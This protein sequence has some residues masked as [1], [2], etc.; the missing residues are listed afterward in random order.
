MGSL[1]QSMLSALGDR[2]SPEGVRRRD[3]VFGTDHSGLVLNLVSKLASVLE[4]LENLPVYLYDAPGSYNL[5]SFSK[6]FRIGLKKDQP[7]DAN[8]LDYT[9]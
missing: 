4:A 2:E 7:S 6:W 8:F 9:G 3:E 1:V 5:H